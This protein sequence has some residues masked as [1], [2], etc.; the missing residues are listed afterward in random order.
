MDYWAKTERWACLRENDPRVSG[1]DFWC[2][3]KKRNVHSQWTNQDVKQSSHHFKKSWN[4]HLVSSLSVTQFHHKMNPLATAGLSVTERRPVSNRRLSLLEDL[5]VVIPREKSGFLCVYS[6]NWREELQPQCSS[7]GE[8]R[9]FRRNHLVSTCW[10]ALAPLLRKNRKWIECNED[11]GFMSFHKPPWR[12]SC[13]LTVLCLF[14]KFTPSSFH[15]N[16]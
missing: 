6:E 2:F 16:G 12:N 1:E 3:R 15:L 7:F 4:V 5:R 11:A 10:T 13:L 14:L 8:G 9:D